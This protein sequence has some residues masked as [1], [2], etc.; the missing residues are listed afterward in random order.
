MNFAGSTLFSSWELAPF[1][2]DEI[3]VAE[4]PVLGSLRE[5]LRAD[6]RPMRL[7]DGEDPTPITIRGA[8]RQASIA[9]GPLPGTDA[10]DGIYGRRFA[11][12]SEAAIRAATRVLE[13]PTISNIVAA[14]AP[15]GRA[16]AYSRDDVRL[17]LSTAYCAF[18]SA[19]AAS[20]PTRTVTIHTGFWGCGAYGGNRT[21]MIAVQTLAAALA[22]VSTIVFHASTDEGAATAR[23]AAALAESVASPRTGLVGRLLGRRSAPVLV[24]SV[25]GRIESMRFPW[26]ESDGN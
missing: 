6:R 10:P 20:D 24:E 17:V 2:Q 12:A 23:A 9:L 13:P 19:V 11:R 8:P 15:S 21:L 7:A 3:Q 26:G 5:A 1:A 22:G 4:H 25:I 16:G 14:E 18:A